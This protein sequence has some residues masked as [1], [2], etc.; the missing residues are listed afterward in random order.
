VSRLNNQTDLTGPAVF[1]GTDAIPQHRKVAV[2]R[3]VE[4]Y[5][6]LEAGSPRGSESSAGSTTSAD[7]F[8]V[9]YDTIHLPDAEV[10]AFRHFLRKWD[11]N[12]TP[13]PEFDHAVRTCNIE[14]EVL[15][16]RHFFRRIALWHES[17]EVL[18]AAKKEMAKREKKRN[19]DSALGK[20]WMKERENHE[21]GIETPLKEV[22]TREG[23]AQLL[24][25]LMNDHRAPLAP[26]LF[27]EGVKA[28]KER[29][30]GMV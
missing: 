4:M 28:V 29:K 15:T 14:F 30:Y 23:L 19:K 12:E 26:V 24:W 17:E 25:T 5:D 6:A 1:E 9:V 3:V 8:G 7:P 20:I 16:L 11:Q 18:Q 27:D 2:Q 10:R 21:V 22:T 13:D